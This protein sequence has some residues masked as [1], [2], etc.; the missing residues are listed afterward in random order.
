VFGASWNYT[1]SLLACIGGK[2]VAKHCVWFVL[3]TIVVLFS[4]FRMEFVWSIL[5][6]RA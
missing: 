5:A 4:F 2:V 1:G 3:F 6:R